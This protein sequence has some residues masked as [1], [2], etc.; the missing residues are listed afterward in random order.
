MVIKKQYSE[1]QLIK[2]EKGVIPEQIRNIRTNIQYLADKRN[3]K[4]IMVTSCRQGEGKS[5]AIVNLAYF[6][7]KNN[8]KVLV[9]DSDL[10]LPTIHKPFQLQNFSGLTDFLN[11]LMDEKETIQQV[12]ENLDVVTSGPLPYNP[13]ELLSKKRFKNF[14]DT[15]RVDYDFIFVDAPPSGLADSKIIGSVCDSTIIVVENGK[16]TKN[17][18]KTCIDTCKMQNID[19]IGVIRNKIRKKKHDSNYYYNYV[20]E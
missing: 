13:T 5:S 18:L 4:V 2:K 11:E 16:T 7:A 19:I 9:I 1:R 10:R 6:M 12:A 8:K 17:Q 14:I 15:N 20:K 3:L